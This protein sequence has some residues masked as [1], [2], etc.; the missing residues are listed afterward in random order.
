M[1]NTHDIR[2]QLEQAWANF[3]I[4]ETGSRR[5]RAN[6]YKTKK[7]MLR[8]HAVEA[9]YQ[10][11][12]PLSFLAFSHQ[13]TPLAESRPFELI[14]EAP[15]MIGVLGAMAEV[16]GLVE[17]SQEDPVQEEEVMD[18]DMFFA[19][20]FSSSLSDAMSGIRKQKKG[21]F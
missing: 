13:A 11:E 21:W 7:I 8:A 3:I 1:Y 19:Q 12:F 20:H 9:Y 4:A 15:E 6:K 10:I 16:M 14:L 2:Q 18:E 17:K 5:E